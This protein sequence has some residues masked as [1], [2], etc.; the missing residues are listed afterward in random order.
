M[1]HIMLKNDVSDF[2]VII[3]IDKK[4]NVKRK[5]LASEIKCIGKPSISNVPS[6]QEPPP[7]PISNIAK[8]HLR[9]KVFLIRKTQQKKKIS[10]SGPIRCA[11]G[12]RLVS[13]S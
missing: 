8:A 9:S 12:C 13:L 10:I 4:Q 7:V 3:L 2:F 5:N 6:Y 11:C 1:V